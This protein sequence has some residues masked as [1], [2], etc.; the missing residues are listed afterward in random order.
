MDQ[1]GLW[2]HRL[3]L[4]QGASL[5]LEKNKKY[6]GKI[7]ARFKN[8]PMKCPVSA[9]VA[10][11]SKPFAYTLVRFKQ[12]Y[13]FKVTLQKINPPVWRLIE[14]PDAYD[15]WSL[16]CAIQDAMGWGDCDHHEF[17]IMNPKSGDRVRVVRDCEHNEGSTPVHSGREKRISE[18]FSDTNSIAEYEN[19]FGG[20]WNHWVELQGI[21]PREK[22]V[23]YPR[24]VAGERVCP[25]EGS[26]AGG[27]GEVSGRVQAGDVPFKDP[28]AR[29]ENASTGTAREKA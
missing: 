20:G 27:A 10:K 6:L 15:F 26:D 4:V 8:P 17:R 25:P 13:R 29:W 18:Y 12:V 11:T 19:G 5:R 22:G 21:H 2:Y 23:A 1:R 9:K 24:C 16:H 7:A 28:Q 14:V 3:S